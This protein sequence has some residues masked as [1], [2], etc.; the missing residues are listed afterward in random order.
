MS[1]IVCSRHTAQQWSLLAENA[2]PWT[3]PGMRKIKVHILHLPTPKKIASCTF[4]QKTFAYRKH[5]NLNE[6]L[7][8]S[9]V[10]MILKFV[11]RNWLYMLNSCWH[12]EQLLALTITNLGSQRVMVKCTCHQD[13][14]TMDFECFAATIHIRR[15]EVN[16]VA[17]ERKKNGI[18]HCLH[19]V[20]VKTRQLKYSN[21]FPLNTRK[22]Y[23]KVKQRIIHGC[24]EIWN[25]FRVLTR[26][27]H[28]FALLTREISWSTREL[29]WII[30]HEKSINHSILY[31][32]DRSVLKY[33]I[34]SWW[35]H[36]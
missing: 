8:E 20:S 27:S 1:R 13:H 5:F 36:C 15:R 12:V 23:W 6:M 30:T 32:K 28:S 18:L 7:K 16:F 31:N 10:M 19:C 25:L 14:V 2:S 29:S 22:L 21:T 11:G 17:I 33:I 9:A 35:L 4:Y 24:A 26:I 34:I 3:L